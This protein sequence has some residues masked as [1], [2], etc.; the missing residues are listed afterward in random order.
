[1]VTAEISLQTADT[2]GSINP[3]QK[4]ASENETID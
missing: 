4:F 3:V 2:P 1:M